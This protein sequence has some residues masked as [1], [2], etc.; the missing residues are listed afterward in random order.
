MLLDL[1]VL[2]KIQRT[3]IY[4]FFAL[5]KFLHLNFCKLVN[6]INKIDFLY[7]SVFNRVEPDLPIFLH[8]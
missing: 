7:K 2:Q 8:S 3:C 5:M 1:L 4:V 6:D